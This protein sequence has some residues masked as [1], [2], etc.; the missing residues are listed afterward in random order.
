LATSQARDLCLSLQRA[1]AGPRALQQLRAG[2]AA[3]LPPAELGVALG[4]AWAAGDIPL[5]RRALACLPADRIAADSAL[6]AFL[7]ATTVTAKS[8]GG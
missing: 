1:F 4:L 8:D 2:D 3:L 5:V 6:S 7:D